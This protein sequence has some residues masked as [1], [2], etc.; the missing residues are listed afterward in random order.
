MITFPYEIIDQPYPY[1]YRVPFI[2]QNKS[3]TKQAFPDWK[4]KI[5]MK[6]NRVEHDSIDKSGTIYFNWF[7]MCENR[8][9]CENSGKVFSEQHRRIG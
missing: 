1:W 3:E 8:M 7:A 5:T 9:R 6:I 2:S 4:F